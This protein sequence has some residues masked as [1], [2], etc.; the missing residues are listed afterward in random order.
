VIFH[1]RQ[2]RT[3]VRVSR[4]IADNFTFLI[5]PDF[6]TPL[7]IFNDIST[8]IG[9]DGF[10]YLNYVTSHDRDTERFAHLSLANQVLAVGFGRFY[11]ESRPE[12]RCF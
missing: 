7:A 1:R 9:S 5:A 4:G 6:R 10:I 12:T 8:N 2:R 11:R 3:R